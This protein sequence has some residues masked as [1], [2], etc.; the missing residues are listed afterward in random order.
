MRK[1]DHYW[2]GLFIGMGIG[3]ILAVVI[4]VSLGAGL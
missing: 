4:R 3:L 2:E 1:Q